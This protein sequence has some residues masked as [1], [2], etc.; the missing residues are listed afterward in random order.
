MLVMQEGWKRNC[1]IRWKTRLTNNGL[2]SIAVSP[3]RVES[4]HEFR[5]TDAGDERMMEAKLPNSMEDKVN[6]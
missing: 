1:R 6:E 5:I 2:P 4:S 3:H